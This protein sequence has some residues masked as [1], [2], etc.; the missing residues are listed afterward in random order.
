VFREPIILSKIPKPI[1]GWV[2]PIVIGRHAFGDQYRSTDF[3]APGPGK[4]QLVYTPADGSAATT[5]N[6]YDFKGKGVAMSMY[7]TDEVLYFCLVK[8]IQSIYYHASLVYHRFCTLFVQDG[9]GQEDAS[10]HVY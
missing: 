1:P 2:K 6:V 8:G 3:I 10:F 4:L 9:T 5:L 7:N